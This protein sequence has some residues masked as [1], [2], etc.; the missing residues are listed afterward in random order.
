MAKLLLADDSVT[1]QR[2]IEMTFAGEDITVT[3]VSDGEQA[4]ARITQDRPDIVLAD[5]AM[6]KRNGYEVA[7]FVKSRPELASIPVLLLAGAFEPVDQQRAE[8]VQCDGVLVKPFEPQQVIARVRELIAGARGTPA[9]ATA[10]VPRPVERLTA[11]LKLVESRR[12]RSAEPAP[13]PATHAPAP[14]PPVTDAPPAPHVAP[15]APHAEPAVPARSE[16]TVAIGVDRVLDDY[17]D[18]LDA[19]F[20][21]LSASSLADLSPAPRGNVP[22]ATPSP[23]SAETRLEEAPPVP[24]ITSLLAKRDGPAVSGQEPF[25]PLPATPAVPGSPL[26]AGPVIEPADTHLGTPAPQAKPPD[27]GPA[28]AEPVSLPSL[29]DAFSALLAAELGE[30]PA[31]DLG[32]LRPAPRAPVVDEALVESITRRVIAQ[33]AP[34]LV[35]RTVSELV[36]DTAER[37]VRDEIARIRESK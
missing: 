36:S 28:P 17:F 34:D 19:A 16:H 20:A 14:A 13:A 33:L 3:A 35:R 32:A 29:A 5:I 4:M 11:P 2:V 37:L 10:G 1:I 31:P 23:Q 30:Q 12:E 25:A 6:P 9:A 26:V 27:S 7:A 8:Q 24:T 18:R 15:A 21:N 22:P